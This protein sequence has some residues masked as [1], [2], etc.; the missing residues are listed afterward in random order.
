MAKIFWFVSLCTLPLCAG[1]FA[2]ADTAADLTETYTD[3]GAPGLE[4][5]APYGVHGII[6]AGAAC[7]VTTISDR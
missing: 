7:V 2:L 4:Y 6:G 5:A 3:A 1:S